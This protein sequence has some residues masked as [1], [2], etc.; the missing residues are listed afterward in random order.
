MSD[1]PHGGS[2]RQRIPALID[3]PSLRARAERLRDLAAQSD[4]G[5]LRTALLQIVACYEEAA[6]DLE[7]KDRG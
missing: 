4:E 1:G 2:A 5:P 6:E 7:R 3:S